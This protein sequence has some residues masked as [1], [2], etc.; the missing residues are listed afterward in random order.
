MVGRTG[1]RPVRRMAVRDGPGARPPAKDPTGFAGGDTS[2][3]GYVSADPVN[4]VDPE[5]RQSQNTAA[6]IEHFR[7]ITRNLVADLVARGERAKRGGLRSNFW[8]LL[9]GNV[10][11]CY[12]QAHEF[13]K[14]LGANPHAFEGWTRHGIAL[15]IGHPDARGGHTF[16]LLRSQDGQASVKVDVWS[17]REGNVELVENSQAQRWIEDSKKGNVWDKIG[18]L[19]WVRGK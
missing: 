1:T 15:P 3:Y 8:R 11:N 6:S 14:L 18:K 16:V 17:G 13:W 5:G 9:D 19:P 12:E 10:K 4:F 2:L 7:T